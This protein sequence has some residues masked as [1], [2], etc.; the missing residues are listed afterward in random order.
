MERD[1]ELSQVGLALEEFA[2]FDEAGASGEAH[3][4]EDADDGDDDEQLDE[5]EAAEVGTGDTHGGKGFWGLADGDD[6]AGFCA[7]VTGE[8]EGDG[9]AGFFAGN[10]GAAPFTQRV[11]QI[12]DKAAM[13]FDADGFR[14]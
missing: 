14:V 2:S 11:G 1:A 3:G 5:G 9:A 10:H 12:L 6:G 13:S 4:G 7:F 8:Y